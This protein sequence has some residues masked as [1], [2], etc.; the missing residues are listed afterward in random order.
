MVVFGAITSTIA[1]N[2]GHDPIAWFFFG[3]LLFIVALPMAL[4]LKPAGRTVA[5]RKCPYCGAKATTERQCPKCHRGLPLI[6]AATVGSWESTV[7]KSDDVEKW[8][9]K[10]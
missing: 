1:K 7:A 4:F 10:N 3:G 6:N 9:N 8:T 2:R 5:S